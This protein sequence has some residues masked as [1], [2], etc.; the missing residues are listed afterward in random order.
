MHQIL[1]W[2]IVLLVIALLG[3]ILGMYIKLKTLKQQNKALILAER[4]HKYNTVSE[5]AIR[6]KLD[7]HLLKNALNTIQSHAYQ[8]YH[9]LDKLSNVLDFILYESDL[10]WVK[11]KDEIEFA[12]NLIE[13]NRL[14]LSPLFDLHVRI[15]IPEEAENLLVPRFISINPIENAF[16]HADL[17]QEDSFISIIFEV[18]EEQFVLMVSN[19]IAPYTTNKNKSGG[20]GNKTFLA[21]LKSIYADDY[22]LEVEQKDNIYNV[23]LAFQLQK[24]DQMYTS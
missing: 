13:I 22:T 12:Q 7:P 23:K 16:K 21:R 18:I 24:Y 14:K 4:Q 8:S 17:Q 10:K 1:Y 20:V 3:I 15:R 19:K 2:L 6:Y 9:A 11:L 5:E